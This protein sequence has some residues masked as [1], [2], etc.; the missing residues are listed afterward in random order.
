LVK[1]ESVNYLENL[2]STGPKPVNFKV[3]V[4]TGEPG[5]RNKTCLQFAS[6]IIEGADILD[7]GCWAGAF[8]SMAVGEARSVTA[9]DIEPLALEVARSRTAEVRF[10]EASVLSLPFAESS[11]DVVTLWDVLEHLPPESEGAALQEIARVLRPAG[12]LALSVPNDGLL[13]KAL[14]PMYFPRKHRHYSRGDLKRML[15][16]SGFIVEQEAVLGGL[17]TT[18]DF[19]LFCVW[20]YAL[21]KPGPSWARYTRTCERDS[22]RAGFVELFILA[23]RAVDMVA[24][25]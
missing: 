9:V 2:L 1:R 5:T 11:F 15:E 19:L 8:A 25:G 21:G 14:D 7:V 24:D 6:G 17:I 12:R 22:R 10:V 4:D 13:A 18:F 23:Q 20:K 16:S 3:G